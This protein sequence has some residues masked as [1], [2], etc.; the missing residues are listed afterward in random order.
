[1]SVKDRENEDSA[2]LL[3]RIPRGVRQRFK[4]LCIENHITM[5]QA[6]LNFLKHAVQE[7][8]VIT[9]EDLD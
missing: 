2:I 9:D 4:I 8:Q 6:I 5:E 3:R 7:N 1:M